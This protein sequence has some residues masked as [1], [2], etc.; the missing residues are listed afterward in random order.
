MIR[1]VPA[2]N[3]SLTA[4]TSNSYLHSRYDPGREALRTLSAAEIPSPCTTVIVL[5]EGLGYFVQAARKKLPEARI[6]AV[7]YSAD[8][9]GHRVARSDADWFP[10]PGMPPVDHFLRSLLKE[11]D[12]D[13]LGVLEPRAV[14]EAFPQKAERTR[15]D[16]VTVVNRLRANLNTTGYFGRRWILNAV[17]NLRFTSGFTALPPPATPTLAICA[18]GPTLED[19]IPLFRRLR[20]RVT[21]WA[22]PSALQTLRAN[23]LQ[24]D[25]IILTDAGFYAAEHLFSDREA[26]PTPIAMPLTAARGVWMGKQRV[27]LLHQGTVLERLL[28][29]EGFLPSVA[30]PENPTVAGTALE[31]ALVAGYR[32]IVY[33]GLDMASRDMQSHARPHRFDHYLAEGESRLEPAF[34]RRFERTVIPSKRL[35]AQSENPRG[36]SWRTSNSLSAY[37]GWFAAQSERL[38]GRIFRLFPSPVDPG[39]APLD[40]K[41]FD[42]LV[43]SETTTAS[44]ETFNVRQQQTCKPSS[45]DVAEKI[46]KL[47]EVLHQTALFAMRLPTASGPLTAEDEIKR[48]LLRLIDLPG[49]LRTRR[50]VGVR[51]RHN[52]RDGETAEIPDAAAELAESV[53]R[54]ARRVAAYAEDSQ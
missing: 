39:I 20:E 15:R 21:L 19:A 54:I 8:L 47:S 5:G 27:V 23:K 4:C 18:S 36:V 43:S 25:M 16:L 26:N 45:T 32:H 35:G 40:D 51:P 37:A 48:E 7:W 31:L 11:D 13:G 44:G 41:A 29:V 24:P 49:Y 34:T 22:L 50:A 38:S 9:Y 46:L 53:S 2:K 6:I 52:V 10:S 14:A 33:A 30:V 12:L 3:G 17:A 42:T 28:D 1:I